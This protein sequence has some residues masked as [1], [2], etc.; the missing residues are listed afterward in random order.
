MLFRSD[1]DV[2]LWVRKG[3][4]ADTVFKNQAQQERELAG[5]I[6]S[7]ITG[8]NADAIVAQVSRRLEAEL[9][10]LASAAELL[11]T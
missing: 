2:Y 1:A 5:K 3:F 7:A 11:V 10:E 4:S 6:S 8:E 9:K